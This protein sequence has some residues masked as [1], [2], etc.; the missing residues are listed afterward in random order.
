MKILLTILLISLMFTTQILL[1]DNEKDKDILTSLLN[2][3]L[4]KQ[5][6]DHH[7]DFWADDL[8]YTS[9]AGLRF[10]KKFIMDGMVK[11]DTKNKKSSEDADTTYSA[12]EIDIRLYGNTAIVAFKLVSTENNDETK[13]YQYYFNTGT[14]LKR[15]NQWQ[16]VAWQATKIPSK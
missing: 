14:F 13:K 8:V 4:S 12:E 2:E 5:S 10:D 9:S 1:A 7:H 6:Y 11:N 16:A 3:F 15:N